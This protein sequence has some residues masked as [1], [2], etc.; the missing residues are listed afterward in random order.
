MVQVSKCTY[1]VTKPS[2]RTVR[3]HNIDATSCGTL[4]AWSE[5][6]PTPQASSRSQPRSLHRERPSLYPFID[7]RHILALSRV[8]PCGALFPCAPW[9]KPGTLRNS[10]L[11]GP[12]VEVMVGAGPHARSWSIHRNLLAY[13]SPALGQRFGNDDASSDSGYGSSG[14]GDRSPDW[15]SPRARE[16]G[17]GPALRLELP[18]NQPR[19]FELLVKW[20]YQGTLD[21][22][23]AIEDPAHKW[24]YA[25]T[26]QHLYALGERLSMRAVKNAAIDQFRRGC[27]EA[28]LVPGPEEM[29]PVYTST[30]PGSPFRH[31]VSRIAARQIMD[32]DIRRD[33]STYQACFDAHAA[34]AVDVLNAIRNESGGTLL[35]DPTESAGCS[36]HEHEEGDECPSRSKH[37]TGSGILKLV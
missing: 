33:A 29:E 26:C 13:H 32:P 3:Q 37:G 11:S 16:K 8:V 6:A 1:R 10:L 7:A 4:Q 17:K 23:S 21:D 22:V 25:F 27:F 2:L 28:G 31:L 24:E 5:S 14:A 34:F 18:E 9:L 12:L 35:H 30:P 36:Y 20:L 15:P 19:A